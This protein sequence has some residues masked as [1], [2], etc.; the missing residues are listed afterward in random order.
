MTFFYNRNAYRGRNAFR[1]SLATARGLGAARTGTHHWIVQRLTAIALVPLLLWF[2]FAIASM[3]GASYAEVH[4]WLKNPC[5]AALVVLT[6]G[7]VFHHNESGVHIVVED[8]VHNKPVK[9]II[10]VAIKLLSLLLAVTTIVSV[11]KISFGA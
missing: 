6:L 4:A 10:V 9:L 2:T 11:L 1:T 8:Y 5:T 3:H 7:L